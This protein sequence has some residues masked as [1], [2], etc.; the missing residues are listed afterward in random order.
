MQIIDISR[1]LFSAAVYPGDP[2]SRLERIRR[3]ETGDE[4]NLTA[5]TCCSHAATHVD[6]PLHYLADGVGVSDLPLGDFYGPCSVVTVDGLITG[7]DIDAILPLVEKRILFRG[8]ERAFLLPSAAF[9]L[10]DGGVTLVGTDA[11]TVALEEDCTAVHTE[12]LAAGVRILEGLSLSH[13]ADGRYTLAAC[14]LKLAGLDGAPGRAVLL[15]EV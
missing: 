12:L 3:L 5:L 7:A 10:A 14:P 4:Y 2:E 11:P 6:A 9:A 15:G 1:E 13:V 8:L